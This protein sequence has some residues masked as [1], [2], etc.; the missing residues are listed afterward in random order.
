MNGTALPILLAAM[1]PRSHNCFRFCYG[2]TA[3]GRNRLPLPHGLHSAVFSKHGGV[4]VVSEQTLQ[5]DIHQR[6]YRGD[7]TLAGE[8]PSLAEKP[9]FAANLELTVVSQDPPLR[10][11]IIRP[12]NFDRNRRYPVIVHVYGG[13]HG[14]TVLA[15]GRSYLLEQ[16]LA[17]Q[18]FIIVSIDGRGTPARGRDFERSIKGNFVE[19][20]LTDQVRGLKALGKN[21]RKWISDT[22]A[23]SAGHSADTCRRLR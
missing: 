8:I 16:W 12:R 23:S 11:A 6:V 2:R 3:H 19:L 4:H 1:I 15:S 17:D 13:P 20:A 9:P 22:S 5:G 10:A 21:M 7:Q 18:G 14:Q